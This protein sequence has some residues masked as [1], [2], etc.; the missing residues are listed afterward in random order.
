MRISVRDNIE[1]ALTSYGKTKRGE[2]IKNNIDQC[3]FTASQIMWTDEA[4]KAM[5]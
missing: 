2:W 5:R 4:E 3:V 1:K